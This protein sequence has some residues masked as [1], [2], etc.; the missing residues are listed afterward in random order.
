[1]ARNRWLWIGCGGCLGLVIL[2]VLMLF[3]GGFAINRYVKSIQSQK[4]QWDQKV[5][6]LDQ[7]HPYTPSIPPTLDPQR[8]TDYLEIRKRAAASVDQKLGWL[9]E[10]SRAAATQKE[11]ESWLS[12][13]KR[14]LHLPFNL[15]EIGEDQ[16]N[17]LTEARMSMREYV[18][19]TQITAG[20]MNQWRQREAGDARRAIA[21]AY[22]KPILDLDESLQKHKQKNQHTHIDIGPFNKEDF[23]YTL[24][25]QPS[26]TPEMDDTIFAARDRIVSASSGVFLDAITL[27][28]VKEIKTPSAP[29]GEAAPSEPASAPAP[30]ASD[31]ALDHATG[32]T[33]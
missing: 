24:K 28:N 8:Y 22:L 18:H 33:P 5:K 20:T 15:L 29:A 10:L 32:E 17:A 13:V 12:L 2:L 1:M 27:Q 16:V 21:E 4:D 9:I 6:A 14:F 11:P 26:P 30:S 19:L 23:L 3:A 25:N 31:A 7:A